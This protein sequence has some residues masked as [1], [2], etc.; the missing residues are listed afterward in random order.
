MPLAEPAHLQVADRTA[1]DPQ[2]QAAGQHVADRAGTVFRELNVV[3]AATASRIAL[4]KLTGVDPPGADP[5]ALDPP[6]VDASGVCPSAL[7]AAGVIRPAW[8]HPVPLASIVPAARGTL[9]EPWHRASC[10]GVV[11]RSAARLVGV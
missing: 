9:P 1:V 2:R 4:R 11:L 8:A 7:D 3:P 10:R 5:S 6:G